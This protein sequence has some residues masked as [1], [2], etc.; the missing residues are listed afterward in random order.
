MAMTFGDTAE[1]FGR[2]ER[3][4]IVCKLVSIARCRPR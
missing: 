3:W 4:S 1:H 2:T